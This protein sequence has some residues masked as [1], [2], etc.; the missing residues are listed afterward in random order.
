[1]TS[2]PKPLK[3][4]QPLYP[5]PASDD[6]SLFAD[7]L[8]VL[9]MTYSDTQSRGTLRYRLLASPLRPERSPLADPGTWVHEYV[10]HLAAELGDEYTFRETEVDDA[11]TPE[12]GKDV[13]PEKPPM[14][15]TI[16]DLR[17]LAKECAVFLIG[18]NAEPD[19]VDLLEEME[20][21]DGTAHLVDDDTFNR[22]CQYMIRCVNLL[23]HRTT[24]PSYGQHTRYKY[25]TANSLKPLP[26]QYGLVTPHSFGKTSTHPE[27]PFLLARAQIPIKWLRTPSANPDEEI[28]IEDEFP[29]D[30]FRY[31]QSIPF[32][33][34]QRNGG[35]T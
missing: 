16:D 1:M 26:S 11:P 30:L 4:L 15:G 2:V 7:I 12:A 3:F 35:V 14:P 28:D 23:P 9:A 6:K 21:V 29:E 31:L 27:T 25:S 19:A 18:H 22:V 32:Q 5:W 34:E 17:S 20:I 33:N 24:S 8:S 10:R 13:A